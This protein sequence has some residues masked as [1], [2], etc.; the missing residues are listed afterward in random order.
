MLD[1]TGMRIEKGKLFVSTEPEIKVSRNGDQYMVFRG[2]FPNKKDAPRELA[3]V[4]YGVSVFDAEV[5]ASLQGLA[6]GDELDFTGTLGTDNWDHAQNGPQ[7]TVKLFI[8]GVLGIRRDSGQQQKTAAPAG[9][10]QRAAMAAV[11]GKHK[12][13]VTPVVDADFGDLGNEPT[14]DLPF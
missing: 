5:L 6:K 7:A 13:G 14:E 2:N 11:A 3:R 4:W 9:G 1:C 8:N 10:N 12:L